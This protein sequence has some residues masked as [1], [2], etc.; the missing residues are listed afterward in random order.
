[1]SN[2]VEVRVPTEVA[3]HIRG[4]QPYLEQLLD[5][6]KRFAV[7]LMSAGRRQ[8]EIFNCSA[9]SIIGAALVCAQLDLEPGPAEHIWLIPRRNRHT[10]TVELTTLLG[11]NGMKA[12]AERHPAIRS[13]RTGTIHR[14]DEWAHTQEPP[15]LTHT[16]AW[17]D[18]GDPFLWY[19]IAERNDGGPPHI[20]VIDEAE[21]ERRR[22]HSASPDR[23]PWKDHYDAMARKSAIRAL[24]PELPSSLDLDRAARID[25]AAGAIT[26]SDLGVPALGT[27]RQPVP[28]PE[29]DQVTVPGRVVDQT[30]GEIITQGDVPADDQP[31]P[32]AQEV[33]TDDDRPVTPDPGAGAPANLGEGPDAPAT[34]RQLLAIT[35]LLRQRDDIDEHDL[36]EIIRDRCEVSADTVDEALTLLDED[37]AGEIISLL[38]G[39]ADDPDGADGA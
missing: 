33:D 8:P 11:K 1:M 28:H 37:Q 21:V 19:A 17:G 6:P 27:G 12:L 38:Q 25:D 9:E 39:G 23:G 24:W 2:A 20:K 14:N 36:L 31:P 32:A 7:T 29:Q 4:I 10:R 22:S 13:V 34:D 16:P 18:R 26:P 3:Q 35:T 5:D 15:S 30:T